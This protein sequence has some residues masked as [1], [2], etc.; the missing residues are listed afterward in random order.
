LPVPVFPSAIFFD[1][2][3]TLIEP[4][5]MF[6]A[7]GYEQFCRRY[8]IS[9]NKAR[10]ERAVVSASRLLEEA[11]TEY[12][13]EVFV[14]YTAH[15]IEKMGGEGE[16]MMDCAREIYDEWAR[17]HHFELYE[18]VPDVLREL[19]ASGFK[20]GLISNS[21]RSLSEFESHFRLDGL[22][23]AAVS[24]SEHGRMKP[25]AR[26]FEAA[27]KLVDVRAE[28]AVMVGDQVGHDIEGALNAGMRAILI[29]R[30][31]RPHPRAADLERLGVPV[32]RSLRD[33]PTA[34]RQSP[35]P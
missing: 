34:L 10:F 15:I 6:R 12:D 35:E 1:V 22:I 2:D 13:D 26:I 19:A 3:F 31:D 11:A 18:D 24:S 9:V 21:H 23:T 16:R 27:L 8:G 32:I 20:L 25:D 4:G 28:Q 33:L 30:T 17:C 29:H 14:K 7:E 5:P